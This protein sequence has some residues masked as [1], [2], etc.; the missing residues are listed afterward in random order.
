M[1]QPRLQIFVRSLVGKPFLLASALCCIFVGQVA[2]SDDVF[3]GPK[4]KDE[5]PFNGSNVR[6]GGG[7]TCSEEYARNQLITDKRTIVADVKK[8]I[9]RSFGIEK[10]IGMDFGFASPYDKCVIPSSYDARPPANNPLWPVCCAV[11]VAGSG[12]YR[13]SCRVFFTAKQ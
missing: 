8:C 12:N 10:D 6:S 5:A 9:N 3:P 13:M 4:V 11:P 2:A 1:R 7:I